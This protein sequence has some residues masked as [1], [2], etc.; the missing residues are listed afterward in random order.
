MQT[1]LPDNLEIEVDTFSCIG[2]WSPEEDGTTSAPVSLEEG[3]RNIQ[4]NAFVI[5]Y[6]E[7]MRC[8][9]SGVGH[10]GKFNASKDSLPL[11]GVAPVCSLEMLGDRSFCEDHGLRYPYY[12][13][14][15]ANGI[16]SEE[17]VETM[18]RAGMLGFFGAAGLP[19]KRIEAALKRLTESMAGLPFGFNLI[20]SPN[21][22]RWQQEV[23]DLYL[24][25][26]LRLV[27]AS[28]YI[29]LTQP[30]IKYRVTGLYRD[31]S[32][33]VVAPNKVIAKVSRAEVAKRFFSPPPARMLEKLLANGE[34]TEEE[35]TLAQE[36]PVAQDLTAESDSGGHT[37]HRPAITLLPAL[38]KLRD[39]MQAEHNYAEKLR[40]GLGGGVGAPMAAAA[41]FSMGAA[42]IVTGSVNQACVEAGTSVYVKDL[43]AG[44][45][46]T[47]VEK[48]PAADMFE[49]G[50]TVQVLKKGCR[51]GVRGAKLYELYKDYDSIDEIPEEER[52]KLE[53][54]I[55]RASLDEIWEQTQNY[56][57]E[58][59]PTQIDKAEKRPR[60]K[61]ALIFRWY[62]G[63]S[64]AWALRGVED[65]Q[66]DYQ[67][68]CGPAMGAFNEWSKGSYLE[69]PANRKVV[70]VGM[71]I[72][73]GAAVQTRVSNL[74]QQGLELPVGIEQM[75]PKPLDELEPLISVL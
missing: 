48:A 68:W 31:E 73:F 30:L 43:L 32:G 8:M 18:G 41:A 40:V 50:V 33:N 39:E 72:L 36:I 74:R 51:Y 29:S 27:E 49:M 63:Q 66:A 17:L 14:A 45:G 1:K 65:R 11:M 26:G 44:A 70:E 35:A 3:I 5:P 56:F 69:D 34:I 2:S 16:S 24:K 15:M 7:E 54:Q 46:Q 71:N 62:L 4:E 19:P 20:N 57:R 21:E 10:I 47:D 9:L 12:A 55:F 13:G 67:I 37:D 38:I 6:G 60:H 52:A 25:Y 23:A 64:S 61:M 59:D 42:Y 75:A 58:I 53:E 22:P 28:A